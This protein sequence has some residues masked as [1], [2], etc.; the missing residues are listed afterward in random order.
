MHTASPNLFLCHAVR[1]HSLPDSA[2]LLVLLLVPC[3]LCLGA[4]FPVSLPSFSF[5]ALDLS[6]PLSFCDGISL[7]YDVFL[8][9]IL[10]SLVRQSSPSYQVRG[11]PRETLPLLSPWPLAS[12]LGRRQAVKLILGLVTFSVPLLQWLALCHGASRLFLVL[13]IIFASLSS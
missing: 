6:C 11:V 8:I 2:L 1:L 3:A 12:L 10:N 5:Q 7:L 13:L 4:R 9:S